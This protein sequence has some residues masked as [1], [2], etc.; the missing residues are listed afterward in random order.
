MTVHMLQLNLNLSGWF[1]QYAASTAV[2]LRAPA[3]TVDQQNVLPASSRTTGKSGR[4]AAIKGARKHL[5]R[6]SGAG[7]AAPTNSQQP[8]H[9]QQR[10]AIGGDYCCCIG[11]DKPRYYHSSTDQQLIQQWA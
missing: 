5:P 7:G 6:F 9:P 11:L 8:Q 10:W 2:Q 4:S 3:K 1:S